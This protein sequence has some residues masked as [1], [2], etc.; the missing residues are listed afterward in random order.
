[1]EIT[2]TP[3]K[4]CDLVKA[5][6]RLDSNTAPDLERAFNRLMEEG[7]RY[8]IVFDMSEITYVSSKGW[9]VMIE[10][11]KKCKRYRRGELVLAAIPREISESLNLVGM[12]KY[13]TTFENA[14]SGVGY[15]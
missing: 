6:G 4:H 8:K 3:Y 5:V 7:S 13:F 9:W 1:M 10:T 11:L 2:I 15:F 14:T 12:G